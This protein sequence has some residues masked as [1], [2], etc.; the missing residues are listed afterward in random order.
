MHERGREDH[1]ADG[2]A[3][4]DFRGEL[5]RELGLRDE[6]LR[7][8]PISVPDQYVPA[9]DEH[10]GDVVFASWPS[11]KQQ[12][13]VGKY[14]E[15]VLTMNSGACELAELQSVCC[16][17][18]PDLFF[19]RSA[20]AVKI[21]NL[22]DLRIRLGQEAFERRIVETIRRLSTKRRSRYRRC[23][24]CHEMTPPGAFFRGAICLNCAH[25]Q[26]GVVF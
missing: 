3:A 25:A 4:L 16:A 2:A 10:D 7:G 22:A 20:G 21:A 26:F 12:Y 8:I 1:T 17:P 14:L 23:A 24:R 18:C 15:V 11:S 6:V 13:L 5:A 9:E 19:R